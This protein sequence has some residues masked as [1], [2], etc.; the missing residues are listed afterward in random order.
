MC[1]TGDRAVIGAVTGP[2]P[3]VP[4]V[5]CAGQPAN[6]GRAGYE[7]SP[8]DFR[9]PVVRQDVSPYRC[10]P[11]ALRRIPTASPEYRPPSTPRWLPSVEYMPRWRCKAQETNNVTTRRQRIR[12]H[13]AG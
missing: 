2:D 4:R 8:R 5:L 3:S 1:E 7:T 13:F 6:S 11:G 9:R 10:S 12:C